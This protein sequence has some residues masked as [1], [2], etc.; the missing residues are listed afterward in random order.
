[1]G[2]REGDPTVG[3]STSP[4]LGKCVPG[5]TAEQRGTGPTCDSPWPL[6][7]VTA[8]DLSLCLACVRY[9]V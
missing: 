2:H 5:D 9:P 3:M 6:L 8:W 7:S 4:A 1:M